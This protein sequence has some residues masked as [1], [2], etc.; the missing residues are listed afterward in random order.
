MS[1][2]TTS[3]VQH[4]SDIDTSLL[5]LACSRTTIYEST[6]M[7]GENRK[8]HYMLPV[9][10]R[11]S[12][13]DILEASYAR[14]MLRYFSKEYP[15]YFAY[16]HS[17]ILQAG[18]LVNESMQLVMHGQRSIYQD[19]RISGEN[20][21]PHRML[22]TYLR[23]EQNDRCSDALDALYASAMAIYTAAEAQSRL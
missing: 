10:R 9:D 11:E 21:T 1:L 13:S 23:A 20:R 17:L 3:Y 4:S 19:K 18:N 6:R 5:R 16:D 7:S 8:A 12:L 15:D 2:T 14:N 22:P